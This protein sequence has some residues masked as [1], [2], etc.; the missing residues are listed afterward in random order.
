MDRILSITTATWAIVMALSPLLQ[1]RRIVTNRSSEDVSTGYFWVLAIG[2]TLWIAYG[3]SKSDL[4]LIIPNCVAL[5]VSV[6]TI[7]IASRYR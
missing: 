3:F 1:I 2:F 7:F 4:V 5:L 6:T